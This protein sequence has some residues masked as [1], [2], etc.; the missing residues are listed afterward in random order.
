MININETTIEDVIRALLR[1]AD[2]A[3]DS[4]GLKIVPATNEVF[5]R[6]AAM[7]A[8]QSLAMDTYGVD[9]VV[10]SSATQYK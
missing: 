7:L 1:A 6:R 10:K 4:K 9:A 3:T 5:A 8:L 2:T